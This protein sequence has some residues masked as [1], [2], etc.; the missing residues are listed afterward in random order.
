MQMNDPSDNHWR[1]GD[2]PEKLM[3]MLK[4]AYD[5]L[6]NDPLRYDETGLAEPPWKVFPDYDRYT[7]GW[8]MG[9][10][11]DYWHAFSD[12]YMSITAEQQTEYK[13]IYPTPDGWHGFYKVMTG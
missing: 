10:G 6:P 5:R 13:S 4:E 1:K 7:I 11:E 8:R 9:A 12:W 2:P 3:A